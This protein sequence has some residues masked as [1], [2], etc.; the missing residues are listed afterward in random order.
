ME[1]NCGQDD[2]V[3]AADLGAAQDPISA[4]WDGLW[5]WWADPDRRRQDTSQARQPGE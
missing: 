5:S 3:T 4:L 2:D 1:S